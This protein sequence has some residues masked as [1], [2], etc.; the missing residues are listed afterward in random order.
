MG[1]GKETPRQKMIGMMYLVL[2]ALLA[3]NVSKDVLEAFVLIDNGLM[4]TTLNFVAKN[5]SAYASF[6]ALMEKSAA[7]VG[8]VR[9][10]AHKVK[11]MADQLTYDMQELKV[12]MIKFVDGAQAPALKMDDGKTDNILDWEIGYGPVEIKQTYNIN[13]INIQ[14][15]D[16]LDK[17]AQMM[18]LEGRGAELRAKI[19]EFR[20]FLTLVVSKDSVAQYKQVIQA[21]EESLDTDPHITKTGVEHSWEVNNFEH[22]PMVAVITNLTKLQGDVRN[23]E[24]E[25]ITHL[26]NKIGATDT[27]VNKMEAIVQSRSSY[28]L[29]GSQYEA[30]VLLAAYDSLQR[31]EIRIGPYHRTKTGEYE[32]TGEGKYLPYDAR[33]RAMYKAEATTAGTFALQGILKMMTFDGI[34]NF[35]FYSEYQVV[36]SNVP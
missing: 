33:G 12:A 31:P 5:E 18:I 29:R 6:D 10:D 19:E 34:K 25:A 15:K 36:E 23:A 20:E 26:R 17:P 16:N 35:P 3:L 4:K 30:R 14:G 22:L 9:D 24:A 1:H 21:I 28:I 27:K 7:R 2:T 32:L 8:P 13:G 11:Q